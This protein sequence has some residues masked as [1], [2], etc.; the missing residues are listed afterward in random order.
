M[1]SLSL[2]LSLYCERLLTELRARGDDW[3]R[4]LFMFLLFYGLRLGSITHGVPE[5]ALIWVPHQ[6]LMSVLNAHAN[7]AC[8]SPPSLESAFTNSRP[9][10][11]SSSNHRA[12]GLPRNARPSSRSLTSAMNNGWLM[13]VWNKAK[14]SLGQID[15]ARRLKLSVRRLDRIGG[16]VPRQHY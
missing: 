5:P 9:G 13:R 16:Q 10:R 12:T 8:I 6:G 15:I 11:D 14:V 2:S 3:R 7:L 4:R 1:L